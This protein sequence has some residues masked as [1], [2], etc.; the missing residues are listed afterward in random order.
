MLADL[1]ESEVIEKAARIAVIAHR[2]HK[3]KGDN[4]P[5]IVHPFMVAFKL[6]RFDFS[7]NTIAAALVHDVLEDTDFPEEDLEKELNSEVVNIV[8]SVSNDDSLSWKEKK[9]K[10]VKT[11]RNG[12][13]EAKAVCVADKIHN[14]ESLLVSYN[15]EGAEIWKIFNR[16]KKDKIWFEDEVLKMLKETW[17][18]PLIKEYEYLLE[19]MRKLK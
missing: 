11:V 1:Y 8:R 19:K 10:Y 17:E 15:K 6:V 18:H 3:R 4:S 5:Y 14:L 12:S 9:N 7:D 2:D 13:I 16:G